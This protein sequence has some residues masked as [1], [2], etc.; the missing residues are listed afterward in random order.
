MKALKTAALITLGISLFANTAC[1]REG[2]T[3]ELATNYNAKA[4]TDDGSCTFA[5]GELEIA[6][7]PLV[8]TE[9][10]QYNTNYTVNGRTVQFTFFQMYFSNFHLEGT[11]DTL[12]N[13]SYIL[14]G[15]DRGSAVLP[16][17]P[18]G[19]YNQL[20]FLFGVDTASNGNDPATYAADHP[21][22]PKSP[23]MHWS[24]NTGYIFMKIEGI[25]DADS[26]AD[27]VAESPFLFHIGLNEFAQQYQ[28]NYNL[29]INAGTQTQLNIKANLA[30]MLSG[31]D[32]SQ[33]ENRVTHSM[34]DEKPLAAQVHAN[35]ANAIALE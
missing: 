7:Q 24:W 5:T 21:L 12:L 32:L 23:A 26:I 8:G 17:I 19:N 13:D 4:K 30:E 35:L 27:G 9:T 3:N 28:F 10:M 6:L 22:S 14:V 11:Y 29:A 18:E 2:C 15:S 34:G 31:I 20:S 16:T 1:N 25:V 33:M